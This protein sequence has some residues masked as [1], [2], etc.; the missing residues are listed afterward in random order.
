MATLTITQVRSS[1]GSSRKQTETLKTLG[2]GKI[3]RTVEREDHPS[4]R[5]LIHAVG[6]LVEVR[7]G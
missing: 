4:V 6:H 2:L 3:G 5:G 7:D 1:N